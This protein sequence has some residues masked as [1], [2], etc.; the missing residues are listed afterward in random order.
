MNIEY[1]ERLAEIFEEEKLKHFTKDG[2]QA[3]LERAI[4]RYLKELN[5]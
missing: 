3:A 1:T 5:N 2:E 4:V